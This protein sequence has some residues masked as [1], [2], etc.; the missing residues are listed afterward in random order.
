M[1]MPLVGRDMKRMNGDEISHWPTNQ[2]LA[3]NRE[4]YFSW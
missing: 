1:T 3:R 2:K 4:K